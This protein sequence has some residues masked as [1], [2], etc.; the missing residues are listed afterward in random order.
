MDALFNKIF[1]AMPFAGYISTAMALIGLFLIFIYF[2]TRA[3]RRE[4]NNS[5]KVSSWLVLIGLLMT[6]YGS[7][8]GVHNALN[9]SVFL[10]YNKDYVSKHGGLK[11]QIKIYDPSGK[12]VFDETGRFDITRDENSIQYI[13]RDTGKKSNIYLGDMYTVVVSEVE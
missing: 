10:N 8:W 4:H 13:N 9:S 3:N 11:R 5:K 7:G 2:Q 12:V 1:P 6:I